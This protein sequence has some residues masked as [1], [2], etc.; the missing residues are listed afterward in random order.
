[1]TAKPCPICGKPSIPDQAP[2][3]SRRCRTVDLGR[4]F[5]ED[6]KVSTEEPA[7]EEG[8]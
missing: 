5:G 6:Y 1:M 4:W 7:A 3:C 2:F 8:E